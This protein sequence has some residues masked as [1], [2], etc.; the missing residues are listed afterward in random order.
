MAAKSV[1]D[2]LR[3]VASAAAAAIVLTA[4]QGYAALGQKD[5]AELDRNKALELGYN[6][7]TDS[8]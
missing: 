7:E 5:F 2:P 1:V 6:P 4:F 8:D 3:T